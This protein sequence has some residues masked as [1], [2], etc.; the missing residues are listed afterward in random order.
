MMGS[1]AGDG[2]YTQKKGLAETCYGIGSLNGFYLFEHHS[3]R[4]RSIGIA[5]DHHEKLSN[6]TKV[7][8]QILQLNK[9]NKRGIVSRLSCESHGEL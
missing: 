9:A 1:G 4:K 3:I 2:N 6:E 7:G 8:S 5:A